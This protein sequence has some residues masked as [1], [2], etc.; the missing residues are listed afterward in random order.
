MKTFKDFI[1][2]KLSDIGVVDDQGLAQSKRQIFDNL[3]EILEDVSKRE[4]IEWADE[5]KNVI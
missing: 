5:Y 1:T 4:L 3:D 2:D